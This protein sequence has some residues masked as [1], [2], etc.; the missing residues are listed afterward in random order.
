MPDDGSFK[1]R[2]Y[3]EGTEG[4]TPCPK[5]GALI[6]RAS[7]SCA[8]CG[9]HFVGCVEDIS[10]ASTRYRLRD[11]RLIRIGAAFLLVGL[12]IMIVIGIIT[13]IVSR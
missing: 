7:T 10:Q 1:F 5:C 9:Q 3:T 11:H 2:D 4:K 12:S 13:V 6:A 8:L